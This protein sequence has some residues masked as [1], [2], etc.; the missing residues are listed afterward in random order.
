VALYSPDGTSWREVE[1]PV[2]LSSLPETAAGRTGGG[3]VPGRRLIFG[4]PENT[5][6]GAAMID[7]AALGDR[8]VAVGWAEGGSGEFSTSHAAWISDDGG[9]RWRQAPEGAFRGGDH[10]SRRDELNRIV[11]AGDRVVAGGGNRCCHDQSVSELWVSEDGKG[12]RAVTL[13]EAHAVNIDALGARGSPR[14]RRVGAHFLSGFRR[15]DCRPGTLKLRSARPRKA[16]QNLATSVPTPHAEHQ[17]ERRGSGR[18]ELRQS[19]SR[20]DELNLHRWDHDHSSRWRDHDEHTLRWDHDHSSR[21]RDHDHHPLRRD[22][23]DPPDHGHHRSPPPRAAA[24]IGNGPREGVGSR[25]FVLTVAGGLLLL[26]M[27]DRNT[28]PGR[29]Q[30]W[31]TMPGRTGVGRPDTA[32]PMPV[33]LA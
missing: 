24:K 12:W 31:S 19:R 22:P 21:W 13:P 26:A 33:E 25:G 30:P 29:N 17:T 9:Q 23:Y 3:A 5:I 16:G 28:P 1:V 14:Q 2:R 20:R 27:R 10:E 4:S 15:P 7:V 6:Y 11:S 32:R 8:L 18:T